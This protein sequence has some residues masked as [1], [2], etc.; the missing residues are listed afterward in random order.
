MADLEGN[1]RSEFRF[2]EDV[3]V[4]VDLHLEKYSDDMELAMRLIDRYKNAVFTIHEKLAKHHVGG[5]GRVRLNITIPPVFIAPGKYSWVMCINRPGVSLYD[6]QNDVLP[7]RI[8][9]TGSDFSRYEGLSYGSV[10]AK[11]A[12]QRVPT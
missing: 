4:T 7:F 10:F 9:D 3:V 8:M 5:G 6:L 11:Y 1:R 2:D 12:V